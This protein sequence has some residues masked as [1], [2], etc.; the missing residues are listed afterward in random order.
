MEISP[1]VWTVTLALIIG[2][3]L[4]DFVFH[5]RKAHTPTIKEAALWSAFYVGVALLFGLGFFALGH[6]EMATEYYAGY[7]TEKAL[8]VDNLFV[9]LVIMGS[10]NVP[11]EYQQKV[12]L[13]GIVF[14]LIARSGFIFIGA[15]LISLWSDVF[16]IFGI[17]LLMTA[18]QLLKKELAGDS[19]GDEADNFIIRFARKHLNTTEDFHG[20]KLTTRI[21]GKRMFTPMLLVMLAIGGTDLLFAVDSIPAIYGLTQEPFIVF[22]ATAFSLMGL[23]QLYFL[24]DGL[25]D[26]LIYLSYGLALILGFIGVKLMIHALHEN[27]LPFINSGEDVS[28]VEIETGLSLMVIVGVLII[29]VVA[30]LMAPK[31]RALRA[32]QN[33]EKYNQRYVDLSEKAPED[34]EFSLIKTAEKSDYWSAK[35]AQ[36]PE[37][38]QADLIEHRGNYVALLEKA[39]GL[40]TGVK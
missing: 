28:V 7:V 24:I 27:N 15:G 20:D 40:R 2:L 13:F 29:T 17:I 11:R 33:A 10:F 34:R 16:Y 25:L 8:S 21:D 38:Y 14:A 35:V 19:G 4:F 5:V 22:A 36:V 12:L 30:S 23:R 26:R 6:P 32:I 9:F 39:R 1:L 31:G 37:K 18:G 3:L